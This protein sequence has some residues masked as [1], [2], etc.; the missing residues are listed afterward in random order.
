MVAANERT[1]QRYHSISE[2]MH[3][4]RL[5]DSRRSVDISSLKLQ[6]PAGTYNPA[7]CY[8]S[9]PSAGM[10]DDDEDNDEFNFRHYHGW[11][12]VPGPVWPVLSGP[13]LNGT[14]QYLFDKHTAVRD[15]V[16]APPPPLRLPFLPARLDGAKQFLG[17][18]FLSDFLGAAPPPPLLRLLVLHLANARD[19]PPDPPDPIDSLNPS[20]LRF[21]IARLGFAFF[22]LF[23]R[24]ASDGRS[25]QWR[26]ALYYEVRESKL[27]AVHCVN[28]VLQV[29]SSPSSILR[30]ASISIGRSAEMMI[31]APAISRGLAVP[32]TSRTMSPWAVISISSLRFI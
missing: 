20:V 19:A 11:Q 15:G 3:D 6:F 5:Q 31:R 24:L 32:R 2:R 25:D 13:V 28:T 22:H 30:L 23:G 16:A 27:C 17:N 10:D 14:G 7:D 29:R 12:N 21:S 8:V 9:Q 4:S 18:A 26:N 1:L